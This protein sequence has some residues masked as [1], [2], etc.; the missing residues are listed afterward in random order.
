VTVVVTNTPQWV[1][2][3][4]TGVLSANAGSFY[5]YLGSAGEIYV[6]DVMLVTGSVAGS[7]ANLL[8]NGNFETTLTGPWSLSANFSGSALN[9]SVK[10]GGN[11]SLRI[12]ASAAGSG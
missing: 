2:V 1:Y 5:L 6:D 11:S 12:V 9:T 10:H 7:G 4:Q 8:A 3:A